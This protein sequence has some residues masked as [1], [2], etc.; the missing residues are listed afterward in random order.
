MAESNKQLG[1]N[2]RVTV[3]I[4]GK[5]VFNG[6]WKNVLSWQWKRENVKGRDTYIGKKPARP[7][8]IPTGS[9][10]SFSLEETHALDVGA[11]AAAIDAAELAGSQPDI[12]LVEYTDNNDGTTSKVKLPNATLEYQKA[13]GGKFEK[14]KYD[15]TFDAEV[16]VEAAA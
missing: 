8:K 10:G 9:S 4:E 15:F 5:A 3:F 6:T 14:V 1:A 12:Q 2:Q 13:N 7:W 16:P 11:I